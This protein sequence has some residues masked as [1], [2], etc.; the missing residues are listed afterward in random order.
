ML[1][2]NFNFFFKNFKF[3]QILLR[4]TGVQFRRT[5]QKIEA[6]F[7][8]FLWSKA[9]KN[10]KTVHFSANRFLFKCFLD[11]KKSSFDNSA[12]IFLLKSNLLS[13]NVRKSSQKIYKSFRKPVFVQ[14]FLWTLQCSFDTPVVLSFAAV[15]FFFCSNFKKKYQSV[16]TSAELLLLFF[17]A[18]FSGHKN[19]N[20]GNAAENKLLN[21]ELF[22][23]QSSKL[24]EEN[25]LFQKNYY[26]WEW[27]TWR[28]ECSINGISEIFDDFR[29]LLAQIWKKRRKL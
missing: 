25:L 20:F 1:E 13:L 21:S 15:N 16:P 24:A 9:D 29:V 2:R 7:T 22:S 11:T 19:C 5:C 23:T 17:L 4:T 18:V 28:L 10:G 12:A 3:G 6:K 26:R 8:L 14:M 27:F